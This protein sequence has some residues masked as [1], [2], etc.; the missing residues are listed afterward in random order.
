MPTWNRTQALCGVPQACGACAFSSP[1][2]QRFSQKEPG[3]SPEATRGAPPSCR[4][5]PL[6]P[7]VGA[8]AE[9]RAWRAHRVSRLPLSCTPALSHFPFTSRDRASS[10]V[11]AGPGLV[12]FPPPQPPESLAR[13][14]GTT[15]PCPGPFTPT[16][17]FP[18][19]SSP[20][21]L[22]VCLLL[23]TPQPAC[24][25]PRSGAFTRF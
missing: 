6:P 14:V 10:A 1:L 20:H 15:G 3:L 13:W 17:L 25:L 11:Q 24:K 2:L 16:A 19:H 21:V 8:A 23:R 7:L 4:P 18:W 5:R 9:P 12:I 22:D